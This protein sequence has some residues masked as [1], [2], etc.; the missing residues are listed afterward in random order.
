[1]GGAMA[2]TLLKV[3]GISI[4]KSLYEPE[5]LE[6]AREILKKYS[7]KLILPIDHIITHTFEN[8]GIFDFTPDVSIPEGMI[9]VDIGPKTVR[10]FKQK[11]LEAGSIL[12][13]GP[14]GV[15]E[16]DRTSRGT[17]EILEAIAQNTDAYTL[18]GGGDS[19]SAINTFKLTG[20]DRIS[21][22]GGAMLAFI[23]HSEFLTLDVLLENRTV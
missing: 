15:F 19:I 20:Y 3:Q 7:Q 8:N 14:M 18:I 23:A 4:G 10:L 12:A 6:V 16:W 5:K 13:N 11:L 1:V 9:G 2:Y 21:T 22:G 17:Y